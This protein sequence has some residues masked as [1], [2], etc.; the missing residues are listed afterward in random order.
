MKGFFL[1]IFIFLNASIAFAQTDSTRADSVRQQALADS[2]L[3]KHASDSLL[4]A[5]RDSTVVASD[6]PFKDS[7]N[8]LDFT[9]QYDIATTM[10]N[11]RSIAETYNGAVKTLYVSGNAVKTK[12]TSLMRTQYIVY[13]GRPASNARQ[14]VLVKESGKDKY[15]INI[16]KN[17]WPIYSHTDLYT[18]PK[19]IAGDTATLLGMR[20]PGYAMVL[21]DGKVLSAYVLPG[22]ERE[23]LD[24]AEPF[25]EKFPGLPLRYT[26]S[27]GKQSVSYTARSISFV[28]I[29]AEIFAVSTKGLKQKRFVYRKDT[30]RLE[31]EDDSDEDENETEDAPP[32]T[33]TFSPKTSR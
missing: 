27:S 23:V 17:N 16:S 26:I 25:L 19:P 28:P 10:G 18:E 15:Y 9:V 1:F 4:D 24:K 21:A 14:A 32:G 11:R 5:V 13:Y 3:L 22:V 33:A 7:L 30:K 20:C 12:I 29:P 6:S 31:V 8:T 2:L